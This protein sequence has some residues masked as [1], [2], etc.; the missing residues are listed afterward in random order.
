[1]L[2]G[3]SGL[4]NS[5]LFTNLADLEEGDVFFVDVMGETLAYEV[6]QITTIEPDNG[7]ELRQVPGKDY[8]TLLTCTPIGVNTHRLLVRGER[9]PLDEVPTGATEVAGSIIDPGFPW[10]A[11][12]LAGGLALAVFIAVPRRPRE[13]GESAAAEDGAPEDL[14]GLDDRVPTDR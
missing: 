11:F 14:F 3:H 1:M 10:W 12:G 4:P 2:T 6:D 5:T 13:A 8:V 7:E 9:I